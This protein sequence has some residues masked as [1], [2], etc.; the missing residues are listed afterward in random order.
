MFT[1]GFTRPTLVPIDLKIQFTASE[2]VTD[3][4][5]IKIKD[6]LIKRFSS[7]YNIG[8][9]VYVYNLYCTLSQYPEITNVSLFQAKRHE[10]EDEDY[11]DNVIIGKRELATLSASN[12]TLT[13]L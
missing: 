7:L 5:K 12:I 4:L 3:E 8:S 9:E 13:Q 6:D 11:S 1:I 2:T 10:D